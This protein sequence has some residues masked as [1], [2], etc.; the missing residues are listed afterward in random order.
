MK[1]NKIILVNI[2]VP[3]GTND[4]SIPEYFKLVEHIN[5]LGYTEAIIC[6]DF[7]MPS[8]HWE[9]DD[10]LP[11]TLTPIDIIGDLEEEFISANALIGLSQIAPPPVN[12]NHLDLVFALNVDKTYCSHPLNEELFDRPSRFHDP[13]IINLALSQLNNNVTFSNFGRT[14]L[15]QTKTKL[16]NTIF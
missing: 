14:N 1:E 9:Y 13:I 8:I 3:H 2:Y 4:R 16:N 11:G 15:K 5:G 6:G 7:N 10:I 12:R